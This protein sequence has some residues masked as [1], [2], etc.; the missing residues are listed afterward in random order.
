MKRWLIAALVFC[1]LVYA[2]DFLSLYLRLPR[3]EMSG[4]ISVHTYYAV[5][6]KSGRTEYD[7]AGDHD[8]S[9]ANSLFPQ[10]GL[11]PCWYVARHTNE[12]ITIDS[13]NPKN[14]SLF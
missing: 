8:V 4:T 9:C 2:G 14:P 3:R 5:K 7:Y 12:Q 13:G 6:L 11:K 10:L 1:I